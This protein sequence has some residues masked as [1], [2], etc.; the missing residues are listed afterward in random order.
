MQTFP[1][2]EYDE[3]LRNAVEGDL[4]RAGLHSPGA[5]TPS[6]G[7]SSSSRTAR[8]RPGETDRDFDRRA[9]E[10]QAASHSTNGSSTDTQN[11]SISQLPDMSIH[12]GSRVPASV[13]NTAGPLAKEDF[14]QLGF[15]GN[16]LE[17]LFGG[18]IL[19]EDVCVRLA[20]APR[21]PRGL[22]NAQLV[23]LYDPFYLETGTQTFILD[24]V[25]PQAN[26]DIKDWLKN[27]DRG[28]DSPILHTFTFSKKKEQWWYFGGLKWRASRLNVWPTLSDSK[29]RATILKHLSR[30]SHGSVTPDEIEAQ[31]MDGKLQELCIEITSTDEVDVMKEVSRRLGRI[32]QPAKANRPTVIRG[33]Q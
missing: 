19:P 30:R 24:W 10:S 31:M 8:P 15:D 27:S 20:V 18:L 14:S 1:P 13:L 9:G 12:T 2:E 28:G 5:G 26:K 11:P 7:R 21:P 17:D 32:L 33:G 3:E 23:F 29:S 6:S 16:E 25:T 4:R 22:G